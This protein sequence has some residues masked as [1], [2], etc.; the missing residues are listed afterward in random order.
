MNGWIDGDYMEQESR[1]VFCCWFN[2]PPLHPLQ[3]KK[4]ETEEKNNLRK[5][6]N[7]TAISLKNS[8]GTKECGTPT[9]LLAELS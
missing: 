1:G 8:A 7:D 9:Q 4:N 6:G 2:R 5:P 3:E